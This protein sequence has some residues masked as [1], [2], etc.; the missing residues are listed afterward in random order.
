MTYRASA[1]HSNLW[2]VVLAAGGSRR[3]GYPKQLIRH[4]ARPL[5]LR[6]IDTAQSLA[7]GR[8]VVV[9][10]AHAGRL[11][12]LVARNF[13]SCPVVKNAGW[14]KGIAT[15][16]IT[17]INAVPATARGVL[18]LLTDQPNVTA[19]N[20][21]GLVNTWRRQPHRALASGYANGFGVPAI[22]PIRLRP[23]I[24]KLTGDMGAKAVLGQATS[25]TMVVDMPQAAF[26]ID[27][28]DDYQRLQ[29]YRR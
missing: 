21:S 5:A 10:G 7:P 8:V 1:A 13:R 14:E 18:I 24:R 2:C 4:H 11:R 9:L 23:A 25:K 28:A 3:L 16:L 15:S 6:A 12:A 29:R 19:R 26:D 27:T 22:L 20:L 17:G